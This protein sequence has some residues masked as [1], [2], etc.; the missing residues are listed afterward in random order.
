MA[1]KDE[2]ANA[3]L[4]GVSDF[5]NDITSV[6]VKMFSAP[7]DEEKVISSCVLYVGIIL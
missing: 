1:G 7:N 4:G 5:I 3:V 6:F 2:I